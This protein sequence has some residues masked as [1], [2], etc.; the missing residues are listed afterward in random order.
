MGS[1]DFAFRDTGDTWLRLRKGIGSDSYRD[2]AVQRLYA[3]GSIIAGDIDLSNE[4]RE[5]NEVDGTQGSWSIQEG[6]EN[7][8]SINRNTNEKY[9]FVLEKIE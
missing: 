7:L 9:K 8:F 3:G 1:N 5:P 4:D 6:D 2:L